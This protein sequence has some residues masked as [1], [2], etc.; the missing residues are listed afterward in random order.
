MN[1]KQLKNSILQWAIQGKLVPQDPNDEPASVLL[2]KIRTEK[3][4]LIKEGKIKKDKNE[5]FIFRGDDNSYYEKFL[6]TGEVKCID[7][8]IPFEIPQGWEWTRIGNVFIHASGKQQSSNNKAGGTP[9]KFITTSNLYWGYFVLDNVKVMNFTEEEIRTCSA[10]MGDL[11]VCEGGAGY[12]RSAIW[13]K[14]YD[15]CLQNHIHRLRPLVDGICEYVYY[16]MYLQKES[17]NLAS[18]GTAMPGL[19]ANRLKGLLIPLPPIAEQNRITEKLKEVLP[20]VDK[21]DKVQGELNT[22]NSSLND[23][24]KKSILQEAIQGKLV[25]QIIEEG[26]AKE[27]LAEIR[28]EKERFVKEGKLK[29]SVL[30]D[31]VIFRGDDNKYYERIGHKSIDITDEILFDL[32]DNWSWVRFGHYIKMSIGKTPPRGETKYWANGKYSWVSISDMAD[33]GLVKTTK[34]TV[35]EYAKCLFGDISPLGTLIMSFKLTV[36]RTS[37][38]DIPAYHNEAII[39]IYPFVDEDCST[40]NYLFYILPIISSLGDSK[41]AIKGKTLNSKSLNNLLLPLP[42]L[43]EQKRIVAMIEQ[44]FDKLK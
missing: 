3:A 43:N 18:V 27:L 13:N 30:T 12:G 7:E 41:D 40:R 16:F 29:K 10:T 9:Q 38:L 4:R 21:Y 1:G 8:E 36:G 20:V 19:S 23:V 22:L 39:S 37:L 25:P 26:T 44:L 28:K 11:L 17:N 32:P 6:A 31:S 15:I 14:D 2:E 35:T 24:I 34:E 33:Y 42:P 5:S